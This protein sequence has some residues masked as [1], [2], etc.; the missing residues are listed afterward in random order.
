MWERS[1]I[2]IPLEPKD[3]SGPILLFAMGEDDR[4][5]LKQRLEEENSESAEIILVQPGDVYQQVCNHAYRIN[6]ENQDDYGRLI[7]GLK[8]QNLK[9]HGKQ[10]LQVF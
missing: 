7:E 6:T 2:S 3:L 10:S 5:A 1:D 4:E 9:H 8:V